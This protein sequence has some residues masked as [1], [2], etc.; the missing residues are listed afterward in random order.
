MFTLN[1]LSNYRISKHLVDANHKVYGRTAAAFIETIEINGLSGAT[2]QLSVT[3]GGGVTTH[4]TPGSAGFTGS[5]EF[6]VV[7][8]D[9][10]NHQ[11]ITMR[12]TLPLI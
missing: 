7:L 8:F 11:L 1:F 2:F 3:G 5:S 4:A 10:F 12:E 9:A 6:D